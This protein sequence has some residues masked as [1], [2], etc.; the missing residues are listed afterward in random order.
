MQVT[1]KHQPYIPH[2]KLTQMPSAST[3]PEKTRRPFRS[4]AVST[5]EAVARERGEGEGVTLGVV[6]LSATQTGASGM[7]RATPLPWND[8]SHGTLDVLFCASLLLDPFGGS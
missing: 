3:S 5:E 4:P 2:P 6:R 8:A 7:P 1:P